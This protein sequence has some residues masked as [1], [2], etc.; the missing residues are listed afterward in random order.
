[1]TY[2]SYFAW[3]CA[4]AVL[5]L[6]LIYEPLFPDFLRVKMDELRAK[7]RFLAMQIEHEKEILLISVDKTRHVDK[8]KAICE[9]LGIEMP[10]E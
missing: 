5:A 2:L 3:L 7:A 10:H 4:G 8:A 9:E 1:M 6:V